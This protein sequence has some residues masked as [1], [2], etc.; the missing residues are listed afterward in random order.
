M[1]RQ[2]LPHYVR[3]GEMTW[4]RASPDDAEEIVWRLRYG[5]PTRS[6]LLY[7][8]DAM[9]AYQSLVWKTRDR[10]EEIIR[11]LRAAEESEVAP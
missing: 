10:R 2:V 9:Q 5:T 6:D 11:E 1:T 3:F 4:P 7:A 8:A